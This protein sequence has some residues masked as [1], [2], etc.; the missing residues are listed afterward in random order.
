[1][2][3]IN[4]TGTG[5]I[6][7][8]SAGAANVNINQSAPPYGTYNGGDNDMR[9]SAPNVPNMEGGITYTYMC[10]IYSAPGTTAT[11]G[12]GGISSSSLGTLIQANDCFKLCVNDN[13]YIKYFFYR[14]N[15]DVDNFIFDD[16]TDF[17][18]NGKGWTHVCVT[19]TSGTNNVKLYLNGVF[20]ENGI[21][22][23]TTNGLDS[24]TVI[25]NNDEPIRILA[26]ND[27]DEVFYGSIT[28]IKLYSSVLSQPEIAIAA[29]KI[30][31]DSTLISS[32]SPQAWWKLDG[33]DKTTP[34]DYSGNGFHCTGVGSEVFWD[35][36][37]FSV[38]V[39]DNTTTT[40]GTTTVTQGK[41]E[42]KALSSLA[43]DGNDYVA[44]DVNSGTIERTGDTT[45][46]MWVYAT[47]FQQNRLIGD[48]AGASRDYIRFKDNNAA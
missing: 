20:K 37:A 38:N 16:S 32:T 1:M 2:G 23:D 28:D 47:D 9:I 39:H 11:T 26:K 6:W 41:L 34:D 40:T 4:F 25:Q 19:V 27:G 44:A 14:T 48:D 30:N 31:I 3:T 15:G 10:W 12:D 8:G 5:G 36:D 43:F 22:A 42:C 46:A 45:V 24:A 33:A 7:E 35:Y 29:S 13:G 18:V 21:Q 17:K